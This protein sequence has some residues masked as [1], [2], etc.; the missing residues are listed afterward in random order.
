MV[1]GPKRQEITLQIALRKSGDLFD[2]LY[3][4]FFPNIL[5]LSALADMDIWSI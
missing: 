2:M 3:C 1:E 4:I 5:V